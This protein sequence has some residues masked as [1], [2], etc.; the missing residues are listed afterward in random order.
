ME[1]F[2][3]YIEGAMITSYH[4]WRNYFPPVVWRSV[5]DN[6]EKTREI[7]NIRM[8]YFC[9]NFRQLGCEFMW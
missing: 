5:D 6:E 9:W 3:I 2:T 7:V 1:Y 4:S 8:H